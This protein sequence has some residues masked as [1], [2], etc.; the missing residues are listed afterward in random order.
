MSTGTKILSYS[1]QSARILN[2]NKWDLCLVDSDMPCLLN[3]IIH[4][5]QLYNQSTKQNYLYEKISSILSINQVLAVFNS[6]KFLY[7]IRNSVSIVVDRDRQWNRI[8]WR[9]GGRLLLSQETAFTTIS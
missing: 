2:I 9:H 6:I 8:R 5:N 1:N 4:P 3:Y 7:T